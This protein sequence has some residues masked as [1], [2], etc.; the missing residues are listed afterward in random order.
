MLASEQMPAN[1]HTGLCH[2]PEDAQSAR[3]QARALG[4]DKSP[5]NEK[6]DYSGLYTR[7]VTIIFPINKR[8][9]QKHSNL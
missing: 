4:R 6:E 9:I 1:T 5:S 2:E 3:T 8:N 7:W